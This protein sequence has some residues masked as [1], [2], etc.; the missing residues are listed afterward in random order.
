MHQKTYA[1]KVISM[2]VSSSPNLLNFFIIK[3]IGQTGM[4]RFF[5][6]Y[7]KVQIFSYYVRNWDEEIFTNNWYA[8]LHI[9]DFISNLSLETVKITI[10]IMTYI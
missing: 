10:K 8:T 6:L 7:Y 5:Y 2:S 1:F 9:V 4:S 3:S